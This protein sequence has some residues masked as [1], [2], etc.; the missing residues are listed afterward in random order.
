MCKLPSVPEEEESNFRNAD[1]AATQHLSCIKLLAID[2]GVEDFGV[3]HCT[4][5]SIW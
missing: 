5:R 2:T 1:K 4:Y 3:L